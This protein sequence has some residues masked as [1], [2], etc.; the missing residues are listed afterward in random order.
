MHTLLQKLTHDHAPRP[1]STSS[2]GSMPASRV[3]DREVIE[4][5]LHWLTAHP[6]PPELQDMVAALV[7]QDI[8]LLRGAA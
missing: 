3:P 4:S 8:S 1:V 6:P 2:H 7:V 5:A